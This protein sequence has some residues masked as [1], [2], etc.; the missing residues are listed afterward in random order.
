MV[1]QVYFDLA[2]TGPTIQTDANGKP[3]SNDK[4]NKRKFP[5]CLSLVLRALR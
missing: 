3:T 4:N 2:W 1:K 5:Q